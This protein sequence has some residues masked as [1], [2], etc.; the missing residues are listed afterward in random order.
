MIS[1]DKHTKPAWYS[2]V[3]NRMVQCDCHMVQYYLELQ[4]NTVDCIT[5]RGYHTDTPAAVAIW[6]FWMQRV[7]PM[8]TS[9]RSPLLWTSNM[10][11][12]RQTSKKLKPGEIFAPK[13]TSSNVW[14]FSGT[15]NATL[16]WTTGYLS[17]LSTWKNGTEVLR[18]LRCQCFTGR[19]NGSLI[20]SIKL[21]LTTS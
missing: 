21:P 5:P 20:L 19:S 1:I 4:Q 2:L 14:S 6:S 8:Q 13:V 11:Q 7:L 10:S 3:W 12:W 15:Q 16:F 17:F 18:K 9:R